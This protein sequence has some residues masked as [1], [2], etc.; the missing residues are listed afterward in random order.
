MGD[1]VLID[2]VVADA[3]SIASTADGVADPGEAEAP[4]AYKMS[5]ASI[6]RRAGHVVEVASERSSLRSTESSSCRR[7]LAMTV[8]RASASVE[9][10]I[11]KGR[12]K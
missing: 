10:R 5:A 2:L 11:E 9:E 3:V 4:V 12:E 6:A 7:S 8:K 1:A